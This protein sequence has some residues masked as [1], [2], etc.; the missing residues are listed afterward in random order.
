MGLAYLPNG[1]R[2]P[3]EEYLNSPEWRRKKADRLAFDNWQCGFC[4]KQLNDKY[5]THHINYSNLGDEH[6]E[7][8]IISL[9]HDCHMHFHNLWDKA[10]KW[11]STPYTHW[12]DYS[13][14]DTAK[15]CHQCWKDDFM[16]GGGY[17]LCSLDTIVGF[18]DKYFEQNEIIAPVRISEEDIRL[19]IRNKRYDLFFE[20]NENDAFNLED[21]LDSKFGPKGG[22]GGNKA[23]AAARSFFTKHKL[24]AMKRI[25][26]ENE[27]INILMKEV[28]KYE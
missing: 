14:P 13:L 21:W 11:E 15:M 2:M 24:T 28:E 10:K 25:Y 6:I 16:F 5:E 26:K 7:T 1:K 12:K 4:H 27:N 9:C 22:P 20:A 18:I 17:N 23:R 8:D 3:Y 19:F